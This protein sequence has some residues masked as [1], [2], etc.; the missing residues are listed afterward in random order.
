[1][2]CPVHPK[3]V[4]AY[5]VDVANLA[6]QEQVSDPRGLIERRV[7]AVRVLGTLESLLAQPLNFIEVGADGTQ[8]ALHR[9]AL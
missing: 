5:A 6:Q 3:G 9:S 4:E 2:Q 7:L 8:S 1:M